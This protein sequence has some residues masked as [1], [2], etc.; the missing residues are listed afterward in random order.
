MYVR[1]L[2]HYGHRTNLF[3]G[4]KG[5]NNPAGGIGSSLGLIHPLSLSLL[6]YSL[7]PT[8]HVILRFKSSPEINIILRFQLDPTNKNTILLKNQG[9]QC[10]TLK[11]YSR[12]FFF[13]D[14][15]L[16]I[17]LEF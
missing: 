17:A 3:K 13:L 6:I 14:K 4:A 8:K 16:Y 11:E 1:V 12:L 5:K 2:Q 9:N 15:S 7:R 10:C